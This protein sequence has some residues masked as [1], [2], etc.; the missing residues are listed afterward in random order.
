MQLTPDQVEF[1]RKT[2]IHIAIPAY[3]G[4]VTEAV[5][6]SLL[7]FVIY[8]NK[9]GTNFSI[10]LLSNESLIS[11][12][13]NTL[14]A[15]MMFNTEATHLM[16]IDADIG[17]QPEHIFQLLLHDKDIVGGCYPKKSLPIDY[18]V[19]IDPKHVNEKGEIATINNL[20]PLTRLGTGFMLIKRGVI[21]KMIEAYPETKYIGNIGLDNKYDQYMY[22]LFNSP[23]V[24]MEFLSEDW[25]FSFNAR[26]IGIEIWGDISIKLDHIGR[27]RFPGDPAVL[28]SILGTPQTASIAQLADG[29][30]Q[31]QLIKDVINTDLS[32]FKK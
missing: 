14:T 3:D 11:R 2:H 30:E 32:D 17:F 25:N 16:F 27:F 24:N 4:M 1:L 19:N 12:G 22:G 8:S 9:L 18:V 28:S 23:I 10:D 7:K 13:R 15:K 20:I 5:L 21:T 26:R 6:T 29:A 31:Q